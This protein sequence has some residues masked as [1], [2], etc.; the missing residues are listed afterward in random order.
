MATTRRDDPWAFTGVSTMTTTRRGGPWAFTGASSRRAPVSS[1]HFG[2]V[3]PEDFAPFDG[4]KK[5][6]VRP[7]VSDPSEPASKKSKPET[8]KTK[9]TFSTGELKD[10]QDVAPKEIKYRCLEEIA[11]QLFASPLLWA[12]GQVLGPFSHRL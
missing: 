5:R 12:Y 2:E 3:P 10:R 6:E 1:H 7:L 8:E 4:D 11:P 9:A